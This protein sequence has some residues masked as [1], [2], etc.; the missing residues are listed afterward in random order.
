M[1]EPQGPS[2]KVVG[3]GVSAL[4]AA[5]II[6]VA[7][8]VSPWEGRELKPYR[9]L[10]GVWTWCEGITKG[11]R[12]ASYTHAECDELLRHEVY[13]HLYALDKCVVPDLKEHE[14]IALGSW[15]YNV[16]PGAA[17]GSTLVRKINAGKPASEWCR[18]LLKWDYAGGK[19]VRGL[20]RRREAEFKTCI[21]AA[22]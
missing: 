19:R 12:K 3:G 14:W 5:C 13:N 18:E 8:F 9:D 20:T 16:G 15:V 10:V 4:A 7:A 22:K 2:A 6:G 17:C 11:V 1:S 21:G